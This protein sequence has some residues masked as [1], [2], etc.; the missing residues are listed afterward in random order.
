MSAPEWQNQLPSGRPSQIISATFSGPTSPITCAAH[1]AVCAATLGSGTRVWIASTT[2][3]GNARKGSSPAGAGASGAGGGNP[4]RWSSMSRAVNSRFRARSASTCARSHAISL[5]RSASLIRVLP[6]RAPDQLT[7]VGLLLL[8][9]IRQPRLPRRLPR[10]ECG[11]IRR[12]LLRLH[13][14][15]PRRVLLRLV[16][17]P[18]LHLLGTQPLEPRRRRLLRRRP[19][20]PPNARDAS[21]PLAFPFPNPFNVSANR[22]RCPNFPPAFAAAANRSAGIFSPIGTP[23][24]PSHHPGLLVA[25]PTALPPRPPNLKPRTRFAIV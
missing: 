13:R 7:L 22:A 25:P 5:R 6:E 23:T 21:L 12:H 2:I 24:C 1:R 8:E 16:P 20:H 15:T 14:S 17:L 3:H 4:S 11:T 9:R 19:R 18:R 10:L